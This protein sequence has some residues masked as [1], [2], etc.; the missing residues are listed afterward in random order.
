MA[1]L[2][3]LNCNVSEELPYP[4]LTDSYRLLPQVIHEEIEAK[5]NAKAEGGDSIE[6]D[7]MT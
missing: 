3:C 5:A 1:H 4:K 2:T 7:R 6:S